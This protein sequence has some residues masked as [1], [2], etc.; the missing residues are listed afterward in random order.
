MQMLHTTTT[1]TTNKTLRILLSIKT[2]GLAIRVPLF[3]VIPI[4]PR[5]Y[6][7]QTTQTKHHV[8]AAYHQQGP[9]THLHKEGYPAHTKF[10]L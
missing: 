1:T 4:D 7:I 8:Q 10:I 5:P 9:R 6:G 3:L 2:H